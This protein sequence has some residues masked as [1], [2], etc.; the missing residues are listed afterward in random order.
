[1]HSRD[2]WWGFRSYGKKWRPFFHPSIP[3]KLWNGCLLWAFTTFGWSPNIIIKGK[4]S[5]A[6]RC[7]PSLSWGI[8]TYAPSCQLSLASYESSRPSSQCNYLFPHIAHLGALDEALAGVIHPNECHLSK[9]PNNTGLR[10]ISACHIPPLR[11]WVTKWTY[12][13]KGCSVIWEFTGK[14]T[15]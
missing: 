1:M 2:F 15:I 13:R 5:A 9:P 10:C 3:P 11:I 6:I 12:T 4:S 8:T 14:H 7:D